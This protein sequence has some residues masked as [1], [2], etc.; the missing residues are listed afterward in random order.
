MERGRGK[1]CHCGEYVTV[2]L[3]RINFD[4]EATIETT[5]RAYCILCWAK[6]IGGPT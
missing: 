3:L 4:R 2:F 1:Q 6:V 5:H